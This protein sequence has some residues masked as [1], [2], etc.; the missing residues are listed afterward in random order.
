MAARPF[1]LEEFSLNPDHE[2]LV[3]IKKTD[4][5]Q[6]ARHYNVEYNTSMRKE[7][8]KNVVV[9]YLVDQQ[10]LPEI[11]LRVL[12]PAGLPPD[13]NSPDKAPS[14]QMGISPAALD[15]DKIYELEKMKL[16]CLLEIEEKVRLAQVQ[17]QVEKD[18]VEAEKVKLEIEAQSQRVEA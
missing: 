9:E 3:N 11:A 4:W 18:R 13:H 17:S 6:L 10:I 1:N 14:L 2:Q 15:A 16:K 7:E 12:T 8:L 5:V